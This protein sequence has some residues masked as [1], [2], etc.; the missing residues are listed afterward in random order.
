VFASGLRNAAFSA[1]NPTTGELWATENSRDNLGDNLPPDE[2]NII[3][4][5]FNYGWPICYGMGVHDTSFDHNSYIRDP[6]ADTATPLF[7]I[8]AH[9]APLGLA[10]V[11]SKQFPVGWGG[12]L[13]VAYHGSW[14]RTVKTGYKLVRLH[15]LGNTIASQEDFITGFV[16]DQTTLGRPV[17]PL[18]DAQ[19]NLF[20]SDD[21]TGSI[22][23]IQHP[24][25]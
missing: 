8:Q 19:G 7:N 18:F 13:I 14:N 15:V 10:F 16:N 17:K 6:C 22:Y 25:A 20:L 4:A 12:D 5:G 11:Q 3:R 1:V 23:I 9:S 21:Y 24:G 2:I